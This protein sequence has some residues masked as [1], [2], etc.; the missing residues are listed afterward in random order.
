[1]CWD[2]NVT[3]KNI[4]TVTRR[5]FRV[6]VQFDP[7]QTNFPDVSEWY[8][9]RE[10]TPNRLTPDGR[11]W[12]ITFEI[13]LP[14]GASIHVGWDFEDDEFEASVG[15][16]RFL[17]L[18]DGEEQEQTVGA[19][20]LRLRQGVMTVANRPEAAE[21]I[22][23]SE[24]RGAGSAE[25]LSLDQL[26]EGDKMLESLNWQNLLEDGEIELAPGGKGPVINARELDLKGFEAVLARVTISD[27]NRQVT[28]ESF[29]QVPITRLNS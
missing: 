11:V 28:L 20:A 14:P 18:L 9:G 7:P 26:I 1:M 25:K 23:L 3:I 22:L 17:A 10:G 2:I 15:G 13:E 6:Q 8:E 27:I 29:H 24:L 16:Y 5:S 12:E 21:A 19:L 4:G